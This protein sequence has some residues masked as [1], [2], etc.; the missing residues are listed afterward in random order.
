[1]NTLYLERN[2]L[3]HDILNNTA[4]G[5]A[6]GDGNSMSNAHKHNISNNEY[7]Q[8]VRFLLP[9]IKQ[10]DSDIFDYTT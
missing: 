2:P 5:D 3:Q 1:L 4:A 7:V 9:Q 6:N 8:K 10:L